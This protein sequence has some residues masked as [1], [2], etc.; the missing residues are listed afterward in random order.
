MEKEKKLEGVETAVKTSVEIN[1]KEQFKSYSEAAAENVM[2][3]PSDGL[4]DPATLKKVVKSVV[5]EEDRTRN[6]IIFGLAEEKNEYVSDQVQEV[7]AE[8]G[9]KPVLQASR[10]GKTSNVKSKRPVNV[11]LSSAS[12][13]YQ[14]LSQVKKL[15]QSAKFKNVFVRPDRSEEE[16]ASD[17]LL[18]QELVK[19]REA[20][21]GKVH[22]IRAGTIHTRDKT[23]D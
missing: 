22:Y 20:E 4:A 2:V 16:R 13:V 12:T 23:S 11:S 8:I 18:V 14:I 3:C 15:R 6:V 21:P 1:L 10:V 5:Q 7:F 9:L 17:R 19:K